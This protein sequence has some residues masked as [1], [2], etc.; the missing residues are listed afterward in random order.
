VTPEFARLS[1]TTAKAL[2]AQ[3][4]VF[5]KTLVSLSERNANAADGNAKALLADI[6]NLSAQVVSSTAKNRQRFSATQAY[7]QLVFERLSELRESHVG[8]CQR[9]GV[10]IERRFK[11]TL[12]YC[13]AVERWGVA[14]SLLHACRSSVAQ[15]TCS[16]LY[17]NSL[18]PPHGRF[19]HEQKSYCSRARG[20]G[21]DQH[22]LR[23]CHR[24][25]VR[26][27]G[28]TRCPARYQSRQR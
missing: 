10:F 3:L 7:A 2:S 27:H 9:L 1:L 4:N 21:G 14:F 17:S 15:H 20:P 24:R 12:R 8:D 25:D 22:V 18:H 26:I 11:P 23:T 13:A 28:A 19:R 6:S 16:P 5:D